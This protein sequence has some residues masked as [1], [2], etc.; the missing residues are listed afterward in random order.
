VVGYG[1]VPLTSVHDGGIHGPIFG[2]Q[3]S[4][5]IIEGTARRTLVCLRRH[6]YVDDSPLEARS[7]ERRPRST[8]AWPS[9][10]GAAM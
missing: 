7:N 4:R 10:W 8:P 6:G 9:P 3:V 2:E 1:V 5:G